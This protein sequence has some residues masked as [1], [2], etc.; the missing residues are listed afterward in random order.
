MGLL[1]YMWY[2]F[3]QDVI[4]QHMTIWEKY[5]GLPNNQIYIYYK[6]HN[7]IEENQDSVLS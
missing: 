5:F 4:M 2:I 7:I 6:S 1:L 3:D